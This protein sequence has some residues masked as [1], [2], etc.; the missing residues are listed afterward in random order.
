MG[1]VRLLR[2]GLATLAVLALIGGSAGCNKKTAAG[3]SDVL[4]LY[5]S[6]S[7]SDYGIS[8]LAYLGER[9]TSGEANALNL[10]SRVI[11]GEIRN[12][13]KYIVLGDKVVAD[14]AQA[15]GKTELLDHLRA[16]WRSVKRA[17]SISGSRLALA[18][19]TA[20]RNST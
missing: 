9:N 11:G 20:L 4:Q 16:I 1:T 12:Q 10:A 13:D 15:A 8:T 6:P 19:S 2:L 17:A 14:R 5:V 18:C 3:G 7:W